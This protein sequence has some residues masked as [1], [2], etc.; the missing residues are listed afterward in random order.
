MHRKVTHERQKRLHHAA[1]YSSD[2]SEVCLDL[3]PFNQELFSAVQMHVLTIQS[4]LKSYDQLRAKLVASKE[5]E[6]LNL[7]ISSALISEEMSFRKEANAILSSLNRQK[8]K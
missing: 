3:E 5:K 7:P 6:K 2:D 8:A 1:S 4:V